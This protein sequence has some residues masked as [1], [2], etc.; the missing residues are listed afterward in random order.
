MRW[1]KS[2]LIALVSLAL[3][4]T[5]AYGFECWTEVTQVCIAS[6]DACWNDDIR[7]NQSYRMVGS[8]VT[9]SWCLKA[10]EGSYDCSNSTKICRQYATV[11]AYNCRD[12]GCQWTYK[13]EVENT[14]TSTSA[15]F[16]EPAC[17]QP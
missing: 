7:P 6:V 17:Y 2:G 11:Y 4:G 13:F 8:A 16:G 15:N 1:K 10:D 14:A 5:L 12:C 3:S 9:S